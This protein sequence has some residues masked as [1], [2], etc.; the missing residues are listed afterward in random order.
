MHSARDPS[1]PNSPDKFVGMYVHDDPDYGMTAGNGPVLGWAGIG[2]KGVISPITPRGIVPEV[3]CRSFV[4]AS[5]DTVNLT[6][7][8]AGTQIHE[9]NFC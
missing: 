6:V 3:S 4:S 8:L 2:H 7:L 9:G 1:L 5:C